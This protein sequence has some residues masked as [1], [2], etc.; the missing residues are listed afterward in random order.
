MNGDAPEPAV[1][2]LALA[3]VNAAADVDADL[4]DRGRDGGGRPERLRG[5]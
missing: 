1:D 5:L 4:L 2:L 3:G